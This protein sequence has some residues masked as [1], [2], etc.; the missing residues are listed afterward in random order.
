MEPPSTSDGGDVPSLDAGDSTATMHEPPSGRGRRRVRR[1]LFPTITGGLVLL[2]VFLWVLYAVPLVRVE[3]TATEWSGAH[4]LSGSENPP[5]AQYLIPA[6][7]FC[8]PSNAVGNVSIS[9]VWLS[10]SLNTSAVFF[11]L[12]AGTPPVGHFLYWVNNTTAGGYSFPPSTSSFLCDSSNLIYCHWYTPA[13]G[14]EITVS[15]T[16]TYNYTAM[17]PIW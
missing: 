5:V 13:A 14:V 11:W 8:S 3:R 2:I 7:T 10:G 6:S 12:T 1:A 9:V 17:E 15:M 16:R 4:E